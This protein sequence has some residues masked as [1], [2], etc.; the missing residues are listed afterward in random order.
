MK[1]ERGAKKGRALCFLFFVFVVNN[2][3]A[4]CD[5]GCTLI[6]LKRRRLCHVCVMSGMGWVCKL[7]KQ[8][9]YLMKKSTKAPQVRFCPQSSF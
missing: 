4:S 5:S 1:T 7:K 8:S 9:P 6:L 2:V 3:I